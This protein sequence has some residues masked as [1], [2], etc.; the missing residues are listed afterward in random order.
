MY[1]PFDLQGGDKDF[2]KFT[3]GLQQVSDL[4]IYFLSDSFLTWVHLVTNVKRSLRLTMG[5]H[6]VLE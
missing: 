1:T 6:Y 5:N 2:M 3:L 4:F